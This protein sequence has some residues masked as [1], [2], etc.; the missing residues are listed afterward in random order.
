MKDQPCDLNQTWPVC[1]KWCRLT[2]APRKTR[3]GLPPKFGAQKHQIFG[4][5]LERVSGANSSPIVIKLRQSYPWPQ[6]TR[7]LNFGRS[8]SKVKVDGGN[9]RSTERPSS[10]VFAFCIVH[11]IE[12]SMR[13]FVQRVLSQS[14]S[15]ALRHGSHTTHSFTCKLHHACLCITVT[16]QWHHC[17]ITVMV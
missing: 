16:V 9:M 4:H 2:N 7:W 17:I 1:R 6:G 13:L 11:C 10:T 15:N 8:R 12:R 5:F 14:A 3:G